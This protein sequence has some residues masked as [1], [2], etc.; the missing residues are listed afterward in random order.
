MFCFIFF[1]QSFF[2]LESDGFCF[3]SS[4]VLTVLGT[5]LTSLFGSLSERRS[6]YFSKVGEDIRVSNFHEIMSK[7]T[8]G[9][10]F[11]WIV[12][13]AFEAIYRPVYPVNICLFKISYQIV[14]KRISLIVPKLTDDI[15]NT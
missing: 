14:P 15:W 9:L 10:I 5:S 12:G 6:A 3:G 7:N 13:V 1:K 8:I 2:L 11:V 4:F